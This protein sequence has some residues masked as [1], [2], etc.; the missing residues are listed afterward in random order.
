MHSNSYHSGHISF[1]GAPLLHDELEREQGLQLLHFKFI[2]SLIVVSYN[3][4]LCS[5][6][7]TKCMPI[8]HDFCCKPFGFKKQ[9]PST[10]CHK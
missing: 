1:I 6:W 5:F 10:T 7:G 8:G 4:F 2:L 9:V 3:D